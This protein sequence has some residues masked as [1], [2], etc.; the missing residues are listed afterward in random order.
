MSQCQAAFR[1]DHLVISIMAGIGTRRIEESVGLD[2]AVVRVMPNTPALVG[3]GISPYC[4]G[5]FA[6]QRHGEL[7]AALLSAVGETICVD[8]SAMDAITATSG[9][10]PAYV[11]YLMEAMEEG[12]QQLGLSPELARKLVRRTVIGTAGLLS[13]SDESAA[14]LRRRVTSPGGTTAAAI[15]TLEDGQYAQL[16]TNALQAAHRRAGELGG[17]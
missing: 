11:Y 16:V 6:E 4:L 17:G 13:E 1:A 7:A 8:E 9:S 5:Q 10:G 15:G 14:E 12:A 3:E 2:V